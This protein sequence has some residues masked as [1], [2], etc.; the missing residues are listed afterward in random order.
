MFWTL[1]VGMG[2]VVFRVAAWTGMGWGSIVY[3]GL[4]GSIG[5]AVIREMRRWTRTYRDRREGRRE[6][7]RHR[8][9]YWKRRCVPFVSGSLPSSARRSR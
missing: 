1:V 5:L 9:L 6:K 8:Q 7:R 4:L 3:L 2:L